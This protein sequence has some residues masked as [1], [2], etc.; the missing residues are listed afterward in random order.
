MGRRWL[1]TVAGCGALLAAGCG[2]PSP[3]AP[4]PAA[5]RLDSALTALATDCGHSREALAFPWGGPAVARLERAALPPAR[6][7]A[8]VA[9]LDPNWIYQ[10]QTMRQLLKTAVSDL[11]DCG[12]TG[13]AAALD[14][15]R[16]AIASSSPV[17][18]RRP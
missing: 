16:R 1:P 12:L 10:G 13:T 17:G 8:G 4:K 6:A 15:A 18:E 14:D 3:Q 11:G 7:L 2:A 9:R 5:Q